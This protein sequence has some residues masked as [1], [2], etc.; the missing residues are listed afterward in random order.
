[1]TTPEFKTGSVHA[2]GLDFH[3]LEMGEGPL[4]LCFHGFPDSP[5]TWR[6]LLP[7]LAAAGY[8]AV[9]PYMRGYAPSAVPATDDYY[10]AS[11]AADMN[12]LNA[13]LGGKGDAVLIG[14]DWGAASSSVCRRCR[15]LA[16]WPSPMPRSSVPSTSGSSR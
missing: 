12:A 2:N 14:H 9:A 11:L 8:R 1:M 4:A 16:K 7:A 6:H 5:M 15:C 13:A 10:G 3:Y